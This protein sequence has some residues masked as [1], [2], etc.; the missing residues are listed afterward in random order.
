MI[1]H[2]D[3]EKDEIESPIAESTVERF[4]YNSSGWVSPIGM[5]IVLLYGIWNT[6]LMK[7]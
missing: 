2:I 1:V 3:N 6:F 4:T 5:Q 7:T